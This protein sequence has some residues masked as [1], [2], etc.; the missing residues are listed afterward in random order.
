MICELH[1]FSVFAFNNLGLVFACLFFFFQLHS[2]S[3]ITGRLHATHDWE[4]RILVDLEAVFAEEYVAAN[5]GLIDTKLIF[6]AS[7]GLSVLDVKGPLL[8]FCLIIWVIRI[9]VRLRHTLFVDSF[10]LLNILLELTLK[11]RITVLSI[12]GVKFLKSISLGQRDKL[13]HCVNLLHFTEIEV[14]EDRANREVGDQD[15][16]P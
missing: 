2:L 10:V 15:V 12:V 16:G 7:L 1:D 9:P 5:N 11:A 3:K 8:L 6:G 13:L 4:V 14:E